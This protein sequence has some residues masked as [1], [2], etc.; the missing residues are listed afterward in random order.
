MRFIDG[1][2]F[3]ARRE[4]FMTQRIAHILICLFIS[5]VSERALAAELSAKSILIIDQYDPSSPISRPVRNAIRSVLES[6][7]SVSPIIYFEPLN[8]QRFNGARYW[9][10]NYNYLKEKYRDKEIDLIVTIGPTALNFI[11]AY[12]SSLWP[13]TPIVFGLVD[14]TAVANPS[15]PPDTTGITVHRTFQMVVDAAKVLVPGLKRIALVG[16]PLADDINRRQYDWQLPDAGSQLEIIEYTNLLMSEMKQRA[17]KLPDHTAL[18]YT[19]ML[20]DSD[21][22]QYFSE[23]ALAEIAEVA[24][25][26]IVVDTEPQVANGGSGGFVLMPQVAGHELGLLAQR[27][28]DGESASKIPITG[29]NSVRPLFNWRELQKWN[30]NVSDLPS[31]SEVRFRPVNAW[32]LYRW[33]IISITIVVSLLIAMIAGLLFERRRRR[34]A[35]AESKSRL[36]QIL[37]MDRTLIAGAMSASIAHEL[38][39]PL[40]A[41]LANCETAQILLKAEPIDLNLLKEILIDVEHDDKRAADIIR[42]LRALLKERNEVDIKVFDL[43]DTIRSTVSIIEPE[44]KKRGIRLTCHAA[45]SALPIF[46][47]DVHLEQVFINLTMN[48]MD[49]VDVARDTSTEDRD[50]EIKTAL[51]GDSE[52]EVSVSDTGIGIP[53]DKLK[54]IFEPFFTTKSQGTGLGLSI[55][56]TIIESYGG[57]IWA[58]NRPSHG[59]IFRLRLPL[60]KAQPS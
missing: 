7:T 54:R 30:V 41:I 44:A 50:V 16:A 12:R 23:E 55:V 59:A 10:I 8:T 45:K 15:L 43:N 11:S 18:F 46:A 52:V 19:A 5:F 40:G 35:E 4:G 39:Q 56:R 27:I 53:S 24:N 47:D 38:N 1:T 36:R 6:N 3:L 51:L 14:E 2:Y 26:P 20:N 17:S 48:A 42:H 37:L 33:Q 31:G 49:A 34:I 29:S 58:E 9:D 25:A 22:K 32:D 13:S 21:G 28:I 60:T 57:R